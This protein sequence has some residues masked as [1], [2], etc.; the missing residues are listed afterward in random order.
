L[1]NT[2]LQLRPEGEIERR[3]RLADPLKE[4]KLV[5][6]EDIIPLDND[7]FDDFNG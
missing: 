2:S 4:G 3:A 7:G 6:P 5:K 1:E